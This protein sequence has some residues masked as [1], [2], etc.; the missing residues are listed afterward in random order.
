MRKL[1]PLLFLAA[2]IPALADLAGRYVK[3]ALKADSAVALSAAD[4]T[5]SSDGTGGYSLLATDLTNA[6]SGYL[7]EKVW[8]ELMTE[9][10]GITGGTLRWWRQTADGGWA[11]AGGLDE[12]ITNTAEK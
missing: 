8:C 11:A 5:G 3:L 7:T 1:L 12:T 6:A 2:S 9:G 4:P 10:T